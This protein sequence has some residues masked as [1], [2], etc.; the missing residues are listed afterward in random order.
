MAQP[1]RAHEIEQGRAKAANTVR[2]YRADWNDF[3]I[4]AE[5]HGTAVLPAS[6]EAVALYV[7]E[8][9]RRGRK[10]STIQRRLS[11]ISDAHRATGLNSPTKHSTV[12]EAWNDV[13][14]SIGT[15]QERK[16]PLL[17]A[18]LRSLVTRLPDDLR[19]ARDRA[20][21][22]LGFAGALRR[23]ELVG[24]DAEDIEEHRW[25]LLVRVRRS[26]AGQ[27]RD[28]RKVEIPYGAHPGTCPVRAVRA[29]L[30]ASGIDSGP[31]FRGVSHHGRAQSRRL[32]D[33]AVVL[34]LKR[35]ARAAG[36]DP[37]RYAGHSLR[38]GLAAAAAAAGASEGSIMAQTGHR[39][40]HMVRRYVLLGT[41]LENAA[42]VAGL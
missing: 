13:R 33:K 41:V 7:T 3:S 10:A 1:R 37:R 31:L 42:V 25:G 32:S 15:K 34:A 28:D 20:L 40:T 4:W 8:L 5:E 9:A 39:S 29:W 35:A 23:S 26:P 6:P 11:A 36:F 38:A 2:A 24:L 17:T 21:L 27:S 18:E 16:A 12:R 30:K 22:L 14:G 19:G